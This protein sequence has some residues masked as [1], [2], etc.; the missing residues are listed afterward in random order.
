M[1]RQPA[2]VDR[3]AR[4][5]T[6][7]MV[8]VAALA[9]IVQR[10]R[11]RIPVCL[12]AQPPPSPPELNQHGGLGEFR[13]AAHAAA[14]HVDFADQT[15]GDLVQH[16]RCDSAAGPGQG[17]VFQR[18]AQGLDIMEHAVMVLGPGRGHALQHLREAGSA[19]ARLRRKIG[20]APKRAAV[21]GQ[22]HGERPA[23]L[24]AHH[25]ERSLVNR[26]QVRAFLAVHLDTDELRVHLRRDV[27]VFETFV[28][29]H[30]APVAGGIADGQ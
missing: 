28:G 18:T 9:D 12:V 13:G 22:E 27:R 2:V 4:E 8:V 25:G 24:F 14:L 17:G 1:R 21:G 6:T 16:C 3:I 7:Q 29:H 20:A 10:H 15:R 11:H 26:I 5:S 19:E 23:A 30:M